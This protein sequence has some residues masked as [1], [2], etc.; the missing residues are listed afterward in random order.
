M[1]DNAVCVGRK[2]IH[3][4]LCVNPLIILNMGAQMIFILNQ[5][6]IAQKI[7]DDKASRV[8]T[9]TMKVLFG[10]EM[11][12]NIFKPKIMYHSSKIYSIFHDITHSSIMRLNDQSM[13]KLFDLITMNFKSQ[14][15]KC[16]DVYEIIES[17]LNHLD[18]IHNIILKCQNPLQIIELIN[19]IRLKIIKVYTILSYGKLL[20]IKQCLF[21]YF[22]DKRIKVSILLEANHQCLDGYIIND[23]NGILPRYFNI[24]GNI[25]LN[26]N[27][28]NNPDNK[29][30]LIDNKELINTDNVIINKNDYLYTKDHLNTDLG[31]DLYTK[32]QPKCN[33]I[34]NI[35]DNNTILSNKNEKNI[36]RTQI[37]NTLHNELNSLA[38]I[39]NDKNTENINV[40]LD[41]FDD[42]KDDDINNPNNNNESNSN[43]N[44]IQFSNKKTSRLQTAMNELN[45]DDDNITTNNDNNDDDLLSLIDI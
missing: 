9:D 23:T 44:I 37:E 22:Q 14:I 15:I 38:F 28:T 21:S 41:I 39:I 24:P 43:G 35:N 16:K 42:I 18:S 40:N 30:T 8:L 1:Q 2:F 7:A 11:Y 4:R 31:V 13:D 25:Y 29:L 19:N 10:L 12:N 6:L 3:P 17:T 27:D 32:R 36:D 5:R 20:I 34:N 33:I 26:T 45:L